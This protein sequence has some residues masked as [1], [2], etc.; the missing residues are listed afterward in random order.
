MLRK[1]GVPRE[2]PWDEET[3]AMIME[4]KRERAIARE[5]RDFKACDAIK[6]R[7]NER[8]TVRK[9]QKGSSGTFT[10]RSWDRGAGKPAVRGT[11]VDRIP[12]VGGT[13]T[14]KC[15]AWPGTGGNASSHGIPHRTTRNQE[16][17]LGIIRA[18]YKTIGR[19]IPG[20]WVRMGSREPVS[21]WP[22]S[23]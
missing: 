4:W 11:P 12:F 8:G 19:G 21:P 5:S 6:E 15:L 9:Q 13:C 16:K 20:T 3:L 14:K 2:V 18:V 10:E 7:L 23:P 1:G 17:A 22:R